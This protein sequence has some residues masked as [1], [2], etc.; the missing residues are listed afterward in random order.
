MKVL[1][2]YLTWNH[3]SIAYAYL[4]GRD[5]PEEE[6]ALLG[7]RNSLEDEERAKQAVLTFCHLAGRNFT[8]ILAFDQI[9]GLQLTME[10]LDGLRT[11]GNNT[12]DL[13]AQCENLLV[14]SAVQTY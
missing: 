5:L 7:V 2:Q 9:E 12:V 6:L 14:L 1:R 11:F 10:D 13:M 4:L 8:I 3:R